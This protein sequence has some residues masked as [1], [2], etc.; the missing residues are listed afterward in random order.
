MVF[1]QA[2]RSLAMVHASSNFS[3]EVAHAKRND[4][5]LVTSGVYACVAASL[6]AARPH[7]HPSCSYVRHPSYV[8]FFY[9]ALGTQLLL[10]NPLAASIFVVVLWRF[11]AHR[12]VGEEQ[13]LRK[14]F[15]D[16][17]AYRERVG[18]GLPFIR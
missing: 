3:H 18:S 13:S 15:P 2:M 5:Q 16:Y 12:I 6:F 17:D 9:W 4:H 8:G 10:G 11:F 14:F 1:G 7:A